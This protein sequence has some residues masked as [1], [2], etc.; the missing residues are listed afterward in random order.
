VST[1][2]QALESLQRHDLGGFGLGFNAHS[3]AGSRFIEP[4]RLSG[5]FKERR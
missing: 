5:D 1:C 4:S 3:H 2:A